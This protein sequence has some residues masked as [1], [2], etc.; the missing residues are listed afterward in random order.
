MDEDQ[1][2]RGLASQQRHFDDQLADFRQF[3]E[4]FLSEERAKLRAWLEKVD[5]V[6]KEGLEWN[7]FITVRTENDE[8][9]E[10]GNVLRWGDSEFSPATMLMAIKTWDGGN[11][12]AP[13]GV[14]P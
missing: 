3:Y 13:D 8:C 7:A 11:H 5:A 12:L 2:R 4:S 9:D 14:L 6:E 1:V 10:K